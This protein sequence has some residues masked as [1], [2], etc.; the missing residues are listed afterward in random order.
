MDGAV[1]ECELTGAGERRFGGVRFHLTTRA[2]DADIRQLLRQTPM[3]GKISLS[4]E[5][6]PS[7]FDA[8]AIEG[9]DHR[10]IVAVERSRL[11]AAGSV[12]VRE[13]FVNGQPMPV[14]YLSGL[15]LHP[16]CRGRASI[17][18]RGYELLHELH[19]SGG[20]PLY[21]TSIFS[22]NLPAQRLLERGLKG[23]P[24]YRFLGELVTLVIRRRRRS[25]FW[26]PTAHVR[27]RFGEVD[28]RVRYGCDE[29]TPVIVDLLNRDRQRYQFAPVC[30][31]DDLYAPGLSPDN[32][33]LACRRDGTAVACAALWDQRSVRQTVVRGYPPAVRRLRPLINVAAA[34]SGRPRL[35]ALGEAL[36]NGFIAHVAA[37][38][39]R[40][41]FVEWF[42]NL[43]HGP[44][45]TWGIDYF[46]IAFDARDP[47]LPHLRKRFRPREYRSRL[48]AA[49]WEDGAELARNLDN[50]L[51][52]PEAALL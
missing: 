52:A 36:S 40:P 18:R 12:S 4:M 51:L 7:H 14:G 8:A 47:R 41:E 15:R 11:I 20:P 1:A 22:D 2:D 9:A 43:L 38:L 33:R 27:R 39:D 50:R 5:R 17:I 37:D 6:E 32:F 26:K 28:L 10:T 19:Q 34:I 45:H 3:P 35:P 49:H 21:L 48:Y 23:M 46:V 25:D 44:G 31:L 42:I 16:S 13:R 24:T 29:L 30:S